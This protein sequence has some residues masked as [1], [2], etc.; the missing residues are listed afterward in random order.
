MWLPETVAWLSPE[1]E[2]LC[3]TC[4]LRC[5]RV[6]KQSEGTRNVENSNHREEKYFGKMTDGPFGLAVELL[7]IGFFLSFH[8]VNHRT[9]DLRAMHATGFW[10][11]PT[12]LLSRCRDSLS[13]MNR[14]HAYEQQSI[15]RPDVLGRSTCTHSFT[16]DKTAASRPCEWLLFSA[17]KNSVHAINWRTYGGSRADVRSA[18]TSITC[19]S[20]FYFQLIFLER[21]ASDN[22]SL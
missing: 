8:L 21:I 9:S 7:I 2:N 3:W 14:Y 16:V 6:R 19:D 15:E 22:V 5:P 18:A 13:Q 20:F 17:Y 11:K 12:I 1:Q 10:R 4:S